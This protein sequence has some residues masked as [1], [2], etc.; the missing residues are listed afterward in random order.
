MQKSII[1]EKL[2]RR[3]LLRSCTLLPWG[4]IFSFTFRFSQLGEDLL[5]SCSRDESSVT[6][7][8]G[9]GDG[10]SADRARPAF[11][12]AGVFVLSARL[13]S[14]SSRTRAGIAG[15]FIASSTSAR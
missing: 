3:V 11:S 2:S 15:F 5:S 7:G 9:G 6:T 4:P 1:V 10:I 13:F 14:T 8:G 12:E